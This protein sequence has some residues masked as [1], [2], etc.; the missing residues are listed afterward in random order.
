MYSSEVNTVILD[1]TR[2]GNKS[3]IVCVSDLTQQ[4]VTQLTHTNIYVRYISLQSKFFMQLLACHPI[5]NCGLGSRMQSK[6]YLVILWALFQLKHI[7]VKRQLSFS[8]T[9]SQIICTV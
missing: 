6:V 3:L 9:F 7:K 2:D 1:L 5:L 4:F 8:F